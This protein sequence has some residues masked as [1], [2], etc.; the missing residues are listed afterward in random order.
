MP[1]S[2]DKPKPNF[3]P[4]PP[5]KRRRA[6][7]SDDDSSERTGRRTRQGSRIETPKHGLIGRMTGRSEMDRAKVQRYEPYSYE[8]NAT[9]F[10]WLTLALI[11][12]VLV[13]LTVAWQDRTTAN[14]LS[15]LQDQG[16][17]TAPPTQISVQRDVDQIL[18][19]AER[20]GIACTSQREIVELLPECV[21]L[22]DIQDEYSLVKDQGSMFVV[23]L[24]VV[25][26]AN[27]FA[28]GAFTHRASR[29][30]LTLKSEKQGFSPEKAVIWFFIPVLNM[31]KPWQV[32]KELFKGSDPDVTT[33]DQSA[34]KTKGK[35]PKIVHVWAAIFVAVF[36]FNP[37]TIGWF[38]YPVRESI[39]DVL[40]AHQRLVIAD[41]LLAV[42]GIAAILVVKELHKWQE[43]RYAKVG[44][45]TV[46]PPLPVDPL[47]KALKEGIRRKELEDRR[48]RKRGERSDK[49]GS[50]KG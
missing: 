18:K 38:W 49:S 33:S 5:S 13:S 25:L 1:D 14:Y 28:F 21:R 16:M 8:T 22:M 41:I 35:I 50:D 27:I 40:V 32:F 48:T 20:E 19:F 10:R 7:E 45:I 2:G 29:N 23:L 3:D 47:E 9:Q 4:R 34:W 37:R 30:L 17:R 15:E 24:I 39:D 6:G 26:L 31:I 36:I 11:A 43:A 44:D 12:W 42:L 46:T